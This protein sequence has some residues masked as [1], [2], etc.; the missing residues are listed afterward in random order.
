MRTLFLALTLGLTLALPVSTQELIVERNVNLR[1][2]PSSSTSVI[3]LLEP[4][5]RLVRTDA[6]PQNRYL[7][8]VTEDLRLAGCG[9]TTLNRRPPQS[10][11]RP[12]HARA[13]LPTRQLWSPTTAQKGLRFGTRT[14]TS[15]R[16][17]WSIARATCSS[18]AR[19]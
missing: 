15:A 18:T 11:Q 16:R 7:Q 4:P 17:S 10:H 13:L 8:V 3:R 2:G 6:A 1:E 9:R 19:I 14:S 12:Q 5:E